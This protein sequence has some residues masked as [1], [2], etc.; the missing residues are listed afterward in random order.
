MKRGQKT[1]YDRSLPAKV[2]QLC[3]EG[4]TEQQI[5][6]KLGFGK[7]AFNIWKNK[8]PE[9]LEAIKRGK[10]KPDE[11]VEKALYKRATGYEEEE[12]IT[13]V[14]GSGAEAYTEVR[15]IKKKII[16]DVTAIIFW[17]KNRKPKKWR[18]KHEVEE[19]T[20]IITGFEFEQVDGNTGEGKG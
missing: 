7:S 17:L 11:E 5:C 1:K 16:P 2:E 10:K 18:D 9:L 19:T 8:Y 4:Y 20:R 6:N 13:V 15:R 3:T 14:R 12:V